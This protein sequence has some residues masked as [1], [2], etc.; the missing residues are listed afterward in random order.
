M[1]ALAPRRLV[2]A[3][4][5]VLAAVALTVWAHPPRPVWPCALAMLAP[6]VVFAEQ[7]RAAAVF[8]F[9]YIY[10]V[11]MALI[12]VRWLLHALS[13]E[14][15]VSRP[16]AWAFAVLLVGVYALVPAATAALYAG[17]RPRVRLV[18]APVLFASLWTLG[19]W[20]RAEP[21]GLPW[22]L[23][24]HPLAFVPPAIQTA[25]LGGVWAPGFGVALAGAGLGTA[26]VRRRAAPLLA[27]LVFWVLAG[28]WALPH[29]PAS[30]PGA[31]ALRIAAV[32]AS[33]PQNEKFQTGS[34]ERNTLRHAAIT[35][36]RVAEAPVDLVV[37]SE[38]AVDVDLD[39][40]PA[41][42]RRLHALVE[43]TGTPLVT[44][45][46][47]Y[48]GGSPRN[49][50]ILLE[51]GASG[52]QIYDK[53][54]L[55]PF[56]ETGGGILGWL[57]P[58]VGPLTAGDPYVAG[59]EPRL[60]RTSGVA[61]AAPICFEITYPHL[62][63]RF[64]REGAQLFLNLSNDAWFGRTGFAR[65]HLAHAPFRAVELRTW[66]V[67]ATNTGISAVIDPSG[68]VLRELGLFREGVL[69]ADVAATDTSTL[70]ARYGDAPVLV[71]LIAL[72]LAALALGRVPGAGPSPR[73]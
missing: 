63:R 41:L 23:S 72:A 1:S 3:A 29:R 26:L 36:R 10:A 18:A 5:L 66:I 2:S 65:T 54:R 31:G 6:L 33:V 16:A 19:E 21:L 7:R 60:L 48:D 14:Y 61:L 47:R 52:L 4:A 34:A 70:F 13:A 40:T 11:A 15:G 32:Q 59:T 44:G 27:P 42:A 30:E 73:S 56:S 55:V 28:L 8:A 20:L 37:W 49:S 68:R 38:T 69:E 57:E 46:P 9:V 25:E 12:I 53:Q 50:V 35:R 62:L 45:A 64:R 67:R 51:P 22:V 58:F 71:A 43:E 24:A 17:L 39:R